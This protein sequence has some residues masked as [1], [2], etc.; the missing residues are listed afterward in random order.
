MPM[1]EVKVEI[2]YTKKYYV[3]ALN[4]EHASEKYLTDGLSSYLYETELDRKV[5]DVI[6]IVKKDN[7][8]D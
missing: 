5:L 3:H 6:K 7:E 1:F 2:K 4:E 8:D